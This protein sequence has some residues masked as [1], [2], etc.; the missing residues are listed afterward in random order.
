MSDKILT[1]TNDNTLGVPLK[2]RAVRYKSSPET[3]VSCLQQ[4]SSLKAV[5]FP[6]P[7]LTRRVLN[8]GIHYLSQKALLRTLS[9]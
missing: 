3:F 8:T 4:E 9:R 6:L 7:S 1:S 2:G 5:G